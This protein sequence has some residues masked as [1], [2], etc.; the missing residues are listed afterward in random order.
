MKK[1]FLMTF[2]LAALRGLNLVKVTQSNGKTR[3]FKACYK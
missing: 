1:Y 3:V 2:L